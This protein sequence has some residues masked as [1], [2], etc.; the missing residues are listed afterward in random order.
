MP[1]KHLLPE[2]HNVSKTKLLIVDD[3]PMTCRLIKIQLEMQGYTCITLSDPER[4]LEVVAAESPALILVDFHLGI[5]GG[6][7]LLRTIRS[8]EEYQ[9]MPVVVMSGMD[10]QRESQLAGANGFVLK[11]FSLQELVSAIQGVLNQ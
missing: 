7:D 6:L 1:E 11:P 8:R 4:V 10:Y 9:H 2:G 3:D 5:Y